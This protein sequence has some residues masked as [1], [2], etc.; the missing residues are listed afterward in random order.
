MPARSV[1]I[2]D[3]VWEQA[4]RRADHDGVTISHVLFSLCEGYA[5]GMINLPQVKVVYSPPSE[6]ASA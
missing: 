2:S 6:N 4:K 3:E 5:R 1:R